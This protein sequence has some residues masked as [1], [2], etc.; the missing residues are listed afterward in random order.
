MYAQDISEEMLKRAGE[1][2][3]PNVTFSL[4]NG[5]DLSSMDDDIADFVLAYNVFQHLPSV[6]V[7][8]EYLGEMVRVAKPGAG[9]C[10]TLT[11]RNL[12]T[13]LLPLMRLRRY[14]QE[15]LGGGGPRGLYRKE[16][17]G[18]RPNKKTV[19]SLCPVP[20]SITT[21]H[22]NKWIFCGAVSPDLRST[23]KSG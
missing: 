3:L 10:F 8:G 9:V 21:L 7:L 11:P 4:S 2:G 1:A 14:V 23:E 5:Q 16:W 6:E 15:Q 13:Y 19:R 17:V 12:S 22:G 18:I 20:V